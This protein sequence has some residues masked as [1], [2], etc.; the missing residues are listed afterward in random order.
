M[1]AIDSNGVYK[2]SSEDT[3]NTWENFLNL[4]MNSVSNAIQNLSLIHI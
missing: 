3:V 1:G 4:G 2:Y